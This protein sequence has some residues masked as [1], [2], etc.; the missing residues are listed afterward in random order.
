MFTS[1]AR[2][3]LHA[4]LLA[5]FSIL[6]GS[7]AL[8]AGAVQR[9]FVHSSPLGNDANNALSPPCTQAAPCR[10]F[11]GAIGVTDPGGEIVLLDTAGYGGLTITKSIKILAPGV[12]GGITVGG[13]NP[14][15]GI[16]INAADTD[17][18]TLRGLDISGLPSGT[19]ALIGID[20][21]NAGAVHIEKS[22][23]SG[24]P[25]D[26]GAC[27]RLVTAKTVRV[28]VDDSFLR[29][30]LTGIYANG[31][32]VPANR[33]SVVVDNT[34]IERGFNTNPASNSIGVWMQGFMDVSLRNSMI[35]RQAVGVQFDSLLGGSVSHLAILNSELTRNTTA[36][37]VV[38][39]TAN[40]RPQVVIN[41]SQVVESTDAIIVS[42]N[43]PNSVA[44]LELDETRIAFTG[45][46]GITL[47]NSAADSASAIVLDM[48]RSQI[49][50]VTTVAI[51]ISATNGSKSYL[52]MK[53]SMVSH[54]TTALKTSGTSRIG[55]SVNH[56]HITQS[57]TCI[58][59][60]NGTIRLDG[61]HLVQCNESIVNNGSP[62]VVSI[63]NDM[64]YD[65]TDAPGPTYITPTIVPAK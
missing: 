37:N 1:A 28:Y 22:T 10:T 54:A 63:G 43:A 36:L 34:R 52:D 44:S 53:D 64:I 56:S 40:A 8:P 61:S 25:E 16:V 21:Q 31:T 49:S 38:N 20:I 26:G 2:R 48:V 39:T 4:F 17:D 59:H 12:Y 50:N 11:A 15:T 5:V 24:F 42:N 27:I 18:I 7:V 51:D 47:A 23:I 6:L 45:A 58:D 62:N 14:N 60:G 29:H 57:T 65:N 32:A 13:P 33:S 3:H 30:C 46:G 55:V 9:T 35:S 41:G 19:P